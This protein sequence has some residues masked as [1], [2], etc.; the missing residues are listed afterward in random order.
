[1]SAESV[2]DRLGLETHGTTNR[3]EKQRREMSAQDLLDFAN[4]VG[5]DVVLVAF[6]DER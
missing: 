4:A 1:M 6:E 3:W 2:D 5:F